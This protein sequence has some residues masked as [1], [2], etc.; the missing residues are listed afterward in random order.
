MQERRTTVR[1]GCQLPAQYSL[2]GESSAWPARITNLSLHGLRLLA[3]QAVSG[4]R[5]LTVQFTLPSED[6]PLT[7]IGMVC[8]DEIGAFQEGGYPI[9]LRF[10]G[11]DD[12]TRFCLQAF[13]AGQCQAVAQM[14]GRLARMWR[15]L[16]GACPERFRNL[17]GPM[18]VGLIGAA[19][20]VWILTLHQMLADRTTRLTHL[21]TDYHD[22]QGQLSQA[23][24]NTAELE[25]RAEGLVYHTLQLD[26]EMAW[27]A[28]HLS[29]LRGAYEH[30][31]GERE[32]ILQQLVQLDQERVVLDHRL[33]S[34]PELREA[35]QEATL[36]R[37]QQ[38]R[39]ARR[40]EVARVREADRRASESGNHGYLIHQGQPTFTASAATN[41]A[42]PM[43]VRVHA[44]E[45]TDS[46]ASQ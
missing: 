42:A 17:A 12:T 10:T 13:I 3:S 27:M 15:R 23:N 28:Q 38:L 34:L 26:A 40:Q 45:M 11:L 16:Q 31:R 18:M 39:A 33:Q 7:V 43:I 29:Q 19:I 14:P 6:N 1:V 20:G 41:S 2:T 32:A 8:W 9:G 21:Q 4:E 46:P 30:L 22:L 25:R 36:L 37:Q 44:P 24:A 35:I 5:P